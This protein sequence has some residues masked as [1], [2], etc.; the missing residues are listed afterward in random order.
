MVV[1]HIVGNKG[2]NASANMM[3]KTGNSKNHKKTE[4]VRERA[5]RRRQKD[6]EKNLKQT[7]NT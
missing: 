5:T 3:P 7:E 6:R 2:K 4:N 1:Q